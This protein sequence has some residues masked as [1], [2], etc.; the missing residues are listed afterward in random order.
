VIF[1]AVWIQS[2]GL[3]RGD[4][5]L[6]VHA[7]CL[8]LVQK[9]TKDQNFGRYS[10]EPLEG[11]VDHQSFTHEAADGVPRETEEIASA[12]RGLG[13]G[14]EGGGLARLHVEP[15]EVDLWW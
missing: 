13:D 12:A 10:L 3:G 1:G 5:D 14:G 8:S 15:A 2:I 7:V 4:R 9:E 6:R 11:R